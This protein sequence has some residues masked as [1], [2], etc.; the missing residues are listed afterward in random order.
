MTAKVPAKQTKSVQGQAFKDKSKPADIRQS[1][2][3]AAKGNFLD[4]SKDLIGFWL[5]WWNSPATRFHFLLT[6][7][8]THVF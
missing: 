6:I 2:I 8:K 5:I 7:E 1:N 3:N 4:Y